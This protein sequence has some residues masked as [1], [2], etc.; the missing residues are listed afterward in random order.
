MI[1]SLAEDFV[2]TA[3][4]KGAPE[5]TVVWR[6]ALRHALLPVLTMLGLQSSALLGGSIVVETVF[7]W[8]GL[9][10]LSF[11]AIKSRDLPVLLGVLLFSGVLVVLVNALV[12][13]LQARLDPRIRVT[14][15]AP[16]Q[17]V[18]A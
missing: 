15:R 7:A 5:R 8:P 16:A 3:R 9:G 18:P 6:H 10:Q 4:A 12:D 11:E 13:V 17:G 14:R 1:E 2:R